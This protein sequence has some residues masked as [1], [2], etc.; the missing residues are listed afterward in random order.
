[1]GKLKERLLEIDEEL[2]LLSPDQTERQEELIK[3]RQ[4]LSDF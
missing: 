4:A 2:R 1:M 3:A